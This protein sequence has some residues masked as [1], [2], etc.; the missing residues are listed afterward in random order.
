MKKKEVIEKKYI[1]TRPL[2]KYMI[3]THKN[4]SKHR[5][6]E[7]KEFAHRIKFF[8]R[9]SGSLTVLELKKIYLKNRK[10]YP[11]DFK[12]HRVHHKNRKKGLKQ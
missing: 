5:E 6:K 1:L 2:K 11:S 12:K 4:W 8:L 10:K 9:V 7:D 3:S